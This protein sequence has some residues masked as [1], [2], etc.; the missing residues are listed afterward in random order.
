MG[1]FITIN[2]P[3]MKQ[4]YTINDLVRFLFNEVPAEESLAIAG[5]LAEDYMLKESFTE[6]LDAKSTLP[7]VGFLPSKKALRKI[8]QYSESAVCESTM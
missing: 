6:M 7:K 5:I 3:Y 8:L 1:D 4:T 2:L